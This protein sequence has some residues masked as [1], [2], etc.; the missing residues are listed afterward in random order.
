MPGLNGSTL[1]LC[2][3]NVGIFVADTVAPEAAIGTGVLAAGTVK[4]LGNTKEGA[5]NLA[6]GL[7]HTSKPLFRNY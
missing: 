5:R 4:V 2:L 7:S 6:E 3:N 1:T